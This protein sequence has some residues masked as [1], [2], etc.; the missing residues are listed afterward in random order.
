M[1]KTTCILLLTLWIPSMAGDKIVDGLTEALKVGIEN[2]I[3][4]VGVEDGYYADEAIRIVL[5]E[6]LKKADKFL[7]KIG[8]EKLSKTLVK[9]MNRAAETAAPEAREL[10]VTAVKEMDVEDAA[11]LL[12]G[13]ENSATTFLREKTG[14]QLQELFYPIIQKQ[15]EELQVIKAFN[16][17]KDKAQ[18][19]P[20]LGKIDMDISRYVTE[21]AMNGLFKVVAEQEKLIREDPKARVTDL[22]KDV[23][24]NLGG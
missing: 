24:G 6:K 4:Q 20:L 12:R 13:G 15:M 23:F 14:E 22:L 19:N 1:R 18:A 9:R 5:P 10:F 11:G 21:E 16:E 17:Y 3:L 7:K 2:A 8:G